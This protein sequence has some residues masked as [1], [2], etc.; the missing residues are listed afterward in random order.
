MALLGEAMNRLNRE[1]LAQGKTTTFEALVC[2][3]IR[4]TPKNLRCTRSGSRYPIG[5]ILAWGNTLGNAYWK[6]TILD[7]APFCGV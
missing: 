3:W 4:S 1:Y 2:S 7:F 6:G 5:S